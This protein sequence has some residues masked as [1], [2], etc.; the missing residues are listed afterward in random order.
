MVC[1]WKGYTAE[2]S[3]FG[4]MKTRNVRCVVGYVDGV[5]VLDEGNLVACLVDFP[6]LMTPCSVVLCLDRG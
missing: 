2:G 1:M 5:C 4:R 3:V 6:L